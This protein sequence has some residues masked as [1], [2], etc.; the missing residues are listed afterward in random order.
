MFLFLF[1]IIICL[2]D[3]P[4][5]IKHKAQLTRRIVDD[6]I[7][8]NNKKVKQKTFIVENFCLYFFFGIYFCFARFFNKTDNKF[9]V[10]F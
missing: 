2:T 4:N 9:K 8:K 7:S 5:E 3:L 1:F 10:K 6:K